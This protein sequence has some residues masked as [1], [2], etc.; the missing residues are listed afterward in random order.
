MKRIPFANHVALGFLTTVVAINYVDRFLLA[1]LIEP[2]KRD[3][4]IS[5]TQVGLLTGAA[6]AICYSVLAL[7]IARLAERTNRLYVLAGSLVV[8]SLATGL[9]GL[10]G[11][12]A[13]LLIARVLVGCGEA[14]A[15]PP[16]HSMAADLYPPRRRATAMAVIG[17]GAA[18]GS[19][20]APLI[21]GV[22]SDA[23]GWRGSFLVLGG[24]GVVLAAILVAVVR[25]P[26]RGGSEDL[27][28]GSPPPVAVV[29][30]RLF[31]RPA[32]R[33]VALGLA[34]GSLGEYSLW[35]WLPP[36]FQRTYGLAGGDLGAKLALFQGIPFFIA[37]FLGGPITD[38]LARSDRRW[39]AWVPM[40]GAGLTAPAI[41]L[42]SVGRNEQLSLILLIAPSFANGL[43]IGPCY[44]MIQSLAAVHSRATASAVLVFAVN[45]IG[46]GL[47]PLALG[48][49]SDQLT[50]RFGA[51]GLRYAMLA[52]PP[53]YALAA[54]AFFA[55]SR[56]L[57][58]GLEEAEAESREAT[59]AA[60]SGSTIR[61]YRTAEVEDGQ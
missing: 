6:F 45:L 23:I 26:V 18:A 30:R 29:L 51:N 10:A 28:S 35:L 47:G 56:S 2:I 25:E 24:A 49:L 9:S 44:A 31:G 43:V 59:S 22:L 40:I 11:S 60:T 19:T 20:V 54:V 37:T 17:L 46:A 13:I 1:I 33:T 4:H 42:L 36:L 27:P 16:S 55:L 14:G 38:R 61:P 53:M 3:L 50:V 15:V 12:F 7:P 41:A 8:W 34:L 39:L 21:G 48:M 5:D 58:R 52:I 32:F 57:L